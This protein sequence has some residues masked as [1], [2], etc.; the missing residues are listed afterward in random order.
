M[1]S[2]VTID[3]LAPAL[4]Q[5]SVARELTRLLGTRSGVPHAARG[6]PPA[7][8]V[9]DW[10][11]LHAANPDE[12]LRFERAIEAAILAHEPRLAQPRVSAAPA[13]QRPDGLLVR[14]DGRLAGVAGAPDFACAVRMG[15]C[16]P[17]PPAR[18]A[19]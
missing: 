9:P 6:R 1:I 16:G 3:N 11:G 5:A 15:A 8:G 19:A 7:Y 13:A 10:T 4:L 17:T 14:I 12:R 18:D 2:F